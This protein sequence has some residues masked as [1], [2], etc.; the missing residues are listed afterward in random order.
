MEF[1]KDEQQILDVIIDKYRTHVLE[2][3]TDNNLFQKHA[4]VEDLDIFLADLVQ[5]LD[6]HQSRERKTVDLNIGILNS[7]R[8]VLDGFD[9]VDNA[10]PMYTTKQKVDRIISSI[11]QSGLN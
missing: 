4:T 7:I 2:V 3:Y 9:I 6:E 5:E 1:S 8:T 11:I 10:Q